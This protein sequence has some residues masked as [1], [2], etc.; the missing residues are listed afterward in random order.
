MEISLAGILW[1]MSS[2]WLHLAVNARV[3]YLKAT[4]FS[5]ILYLIL[6]GPDWT[7]QRSVILGLLVNLLAFGSA[8][9]HKEF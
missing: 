2:D 1:E 5:S 6:K 8:V 3:K 7:C 4:T 9:L